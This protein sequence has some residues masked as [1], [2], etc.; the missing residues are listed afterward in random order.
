ME[1]V[2][3]DIAQIVED[4][5]NAEKKKASDVLFNDQHVENGQ[6]VSKTAGENDNK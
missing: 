1:E 6:E 3:D 4:G 2:A 5:D